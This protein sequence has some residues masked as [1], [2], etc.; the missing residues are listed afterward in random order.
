MVR[1]QFVAGMNYFDER[2]GEYWAD[3]DLAMKIRQAGKKIRLYPALRATWHAG[4]ATPSGTLNASDRI[5]GAAARVLQA[6]KIA[7]EPQALAFIGRAAAMAGHPGW[8]AG[9]P[10]AA[11]PRVRGVESAGYG[12]GWAET[13]LVSTTGVLARTRGT[14]ASMSAAAWDSTRTGFRASESV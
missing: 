5:T 12:D 4:G 8:L 7:F 13:V 3:A 6:E 9:L 11:D 14:S 1:K 10:V 2:F